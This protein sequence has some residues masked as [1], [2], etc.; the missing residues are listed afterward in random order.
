MRPVNDARMHR[1]LFFITSFYFW[2]RCLSLSLIHWRK[3]GWERAIRQLTQM[4][5]DL[6]DV[7]LQASADINYDARADASDD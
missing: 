6:G 5:N 1:I 2:F 4:R 7:R 3:G